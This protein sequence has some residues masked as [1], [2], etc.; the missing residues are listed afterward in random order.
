MNIIIYLLAIIYIHTPFQLH[1]KEI[2]CKIIVVVFPQNYI[3]N[4]KSKSFFTTFKHSIFLKK[5]L[6]NAALIGKHEYY[7]DLYIEFFFRSRIFHS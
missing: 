3:F 4:D 6:A 5:I 1:F 7:T 2:V